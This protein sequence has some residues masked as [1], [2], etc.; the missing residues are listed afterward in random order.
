M[1]RYFSHVLP[2]AH[3]PM[4]L[5]PETTLGSFYNRHE[6]TTSTY[7]LTEAV[8]GSGEWLSGLHLYKVG[9]DLFYTRYRSQSVSEPILVRR[10]DGTLAR[11][12]DFGPRSSQRLNSTDLAMF[13]QNRVQL[14]GRWYT[15]FG[16]RLDRDGVTRRWNLTPRIGAAV[17]LNET[18]SAVLR[19]GYGVFFERTPSAAGVFEQYEN[20]TE[21]RYGADGVTLLGPSAFFQ[22]VT[23]GDL[24]TSR[25]LTW[26][27]AYDH[28]FSPEWAVHVGT[29][30]RRGSRELIVQPVV[31]DGRGELQLRSSG[32]SLYRE[33]E[34]GVH[35]THGTLIDLNVSYVRAEARGDLNAFSVFYDS[36]RKPVFGRNEYAPAMS[37]VP[38]RLVIRG[39]AMPTNRWLLI[40]VMDWRTGLPFSVVN[41]ALDFVGARNSRRFPNYL[42]LELGIERRFKIFGYEPWLGVRALNALDAFLPVDVQANI[43]SP[44]FG[45][46]YNSEYR[47]FRIQA[48]F[49][50]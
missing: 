35:F 26:D 12:L 25:S 3:N 1:N 11:R 22:P 21:R 38:H 39:R 47:Q 32:R 41:E 8:S 2:Q 18:G 43:T 48:R 29:I 30:D 42:R 44:A 5:L 33:V 15:E 28:R 36:V 24:R 34:L 7:Q 10:S 14:S 16:A 40:G 23:I 4:E 17:L 27:L 50:R 31:M 49:V 37:D 20:F 6:R 45:T 13:G 46:F 9:A 19:G